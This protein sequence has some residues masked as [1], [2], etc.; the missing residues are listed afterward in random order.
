MAIYTASGRSTLV[1]ASAN[2]VLAGFR[3][4]TARR[5]YIREIGL[6]YITAPTTSGALGLQRSTA[7]GTGSI[8]AV[9]GQAHDP[10]EPAA[11]G[12]IETDWATAKPTTANNYMKR[13]TSAA[14]IGNGMVWRFDE[15]TGLVVPL[16]NTATGEIV[17]CNLQGT[18][19][20]TF[21]FYVTWEE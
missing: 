11:I 3:A 21:D 19:P 15:D 7:L 13:W 4:S 12:Q 10:G 5:A 9:V 20:G 6:F 16:G 1:T 2:A 18:A 8:T 17:I 14:T